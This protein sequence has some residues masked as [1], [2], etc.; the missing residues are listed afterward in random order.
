VHRSLIAVV[1]GALGLAGCG[2]YSAPSEVVNGV[3]VASLQA[4]GANFAQYRTF[5]V[6][7]KIQIVDNT[8]STNQEYT[9][10]APQIVERVRSNMEARGYTFVPFSNGVVADLVIGLY[11]YK[12]SQAYGGYYCG[13]YYW[14]YYPYNC[15]WSYYGTYYFGT[16]VLRMA[17]FK[18]APPPSS[19]AKLTIV[20]GSASYG[21]LATQPYNLQKVLT[22]ID[23]AFAQSPYLH[24]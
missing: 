7:D 20:W 16:L 10:D 5:T 22:S 2:D 21:V 24:P 17:D 12:G 1:A 11:A 19:S 18:N 14:G 8:G 4:T 15:A 3:A 9:Q 6:T 23:T 13:Y